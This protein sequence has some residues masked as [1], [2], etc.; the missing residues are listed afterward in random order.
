V[1]VAHPNLTLALPGLPVARVA[2]ASFRATEEVNELFSADVAFATDDADDWLEAL[3]I[4][5]PA[6]LSMF[7]GAEIVRSFHGIIEAIEVHGEHLHG[8]RAFQ[9]RLV[10]RMSLLLL[11]EARRAW[12]DVTTLEIAADIFDAYGI[13]FSSHVARV[14][15]KRP[16]CVQYGE[17]D[18]AFLTRLF[19]EDGLFFSFDHP[20]ETDAGSVTDSAGQTEM[21][22]V[23]DT[24]EYAPID[25]SA[26]LRFERVRAESAMTLR[27]DQI[28]AF[29]PRS[30]V[31]PL[32]ARVRGYDFRRPA[33]ELRD[34]AV[35]DPTTSAVSA[36]IPSAFDT[37]TRTTFEGSYEDTIPI[38]QAGSTD[39]MV[40]TPALRRLQALRRDARLADG[41]SFC[42]R[43]TP[44]RKLSLHGHE[45]SSVDGDYVVARVE[46]EGYS[47]EATP[48]GKA[49]YQNHFTCHPATV[50]LR[51]P[52]HP[53]P[54]AT[55][56][57]GVVV[58]P[59]GQD[60]YT[61][62]MGRVRVRFFWDISQRAEEVGTCWVR[63]TQA[64]A[65]SGWGGQF[66]PRIGMEVAIT[67]LDGDPDR[68]LVTGCLYNTTH[69]LP[70]ATPANKT[71]SGI[72]TQSTPDGSGGNEISFED[73][74]GAEQIFLHAQR[75]LDEVIEKNHTTLVRNDQ[76]LRILGGRLDRVEKALEQHVKG[77]HICHVEGNRI[78][79]VKGNFERRISGTQLVRN[80]G[81]LKCEAQG[82]AQ[83]DYSD[84]LTTRIHGCST[85][86]VGRHNAKRSWVTHAE[87]TV[88]LS[89]ADATEVSSEKELVLRVG[90]SSIRLTADRIELNA[91]TVT[92]KG[93]GG[94]LSA[95]DDGLSLSSKGDAQLV[96]E[97]KFVV[98]S[99]AGAS[100]S[101][102]KEVKIDGTQ[103]LLNSPEQAKDPPPPEPNPPTK[104]TLKDT[105][106][107]P[108]GYQ[109]FMVISSDGSEISDITDKDGQAEMDLKS[110]GKVVF[111]EHSDTA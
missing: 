61:D 109:R 36:K 54:R 47:S 101:M 20:L 46:H 88:K 77:D 58:G 33:G 108:L 66:L 86:Y 73:K 28:T 45:I 50:A 79:V 26:D 82:T 57:T 67:Y 43:L 41:A 104:V 97:K 103:I 72:R 3:P 40:P 75:N 81:K 13:P 95:G 39:P 5:G 1:I 91:P 44:C 110:G 10:P 68:P 71:R 30:S 62:D 76:F 102:E 69:P 6:T 42:K 35:F 24:A 56:E 106:G 107:A 8:W 70:F 53:K 22:I 59:T 93:K 94:G 32:G 21:V 31:R 9:L 99:K 74:I 96:V 64:L 52:V 12:T 90:K 111:P 49:L 23:S 25:G 7:E 87:G 19:G 29:A 51:P 18:Y 37:R 60:I 65:G 78:D 98:K 2:V 14:L 85:T 48:K 80:E 4:F 17:T 55:S 27:E 83:Y 34:E 92:A 89:S 15:P 100:L 84:D 11:R 63:T 16:Y 38:T 105:S